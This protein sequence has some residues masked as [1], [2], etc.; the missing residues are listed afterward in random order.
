MSTQIFTSCQ[1]KIQLFRSDCLSLLNEFI[2]DFC[3]FN[4]VTVF[5]KKIFAD[6]RNSLNLLEHCIGYVQSSTNHA[7]SQIS[8]EKDKLKQ[9]THI[10]SGL[11]SKT[12]YNL[13]FSADFASRQVSGI[14]TS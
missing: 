5:P 14:E 10:Q 1:R 6:V 9:G 8:F 11:I 4:L 7:V 2:S 12:N 13:L 3:D